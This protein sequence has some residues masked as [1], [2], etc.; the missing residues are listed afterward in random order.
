MKTVLRV[1]RD[2]SCEIPIADQSVSRVHAELE[3]TPQGD[4]FVVDLNSSN[5]TYL[6]KGPQAKQIEQAVVCGEDILRFGDCEFPVSDLIAMAQS[7]GKPKAAKVKKAKAKKLEGDGFPI[8]CENC[9][10]IKHKGDECPVCGGKS[11]RIK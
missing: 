6:L 2:P 3:L 10:S 1:G 11:R 7:Q 8:R 9:G 5:G 4:L